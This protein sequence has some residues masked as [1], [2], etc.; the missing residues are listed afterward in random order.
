MRVQV[1]ALSLSAAALVGIAV[2]EGY[3]E[4]LLLVGVVSARS[5]DHP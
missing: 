2:H 4:T 5:T 3:R 1:A